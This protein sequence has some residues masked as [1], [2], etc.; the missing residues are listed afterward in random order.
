MRCRRDVPTGREEH[1]ALPQQRLGAVLVEDHARVGLRGHGEGDPRWDVGLDHAGDD[2]DARR[3]RREHEVDADR[4]CLLR[5]A[6]DRVLDVGRRHHHEVGELV[7]DAQDVGQALLAA[8]LAHAVELVERPR[9]GERHDRVARLHLLHE[10]LQR[11]GCHA[12]TRD[13]GRE[14]MRDRLVVVELDLLGV[15]E[16]EADVVRRRAQQDAREHR[17]D[18]AGLARAGGARDEQVGHLRQVGADRLAADVLAQP[19]GQRGPVLRRDPGRRRRAAPS[20]RRW[21]GTSTPTAVLPGTGARMR[22]S[23]A[24]SA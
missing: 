5:E 22:M 24:A 6:D 13:D 4:A 20:R 14:Q 3:L 19:D 10:V 9:P 21:L 7:D 1:V 15:D 12:R 8:P 16:H 17:V 23:V 2:V 11:V 18:R